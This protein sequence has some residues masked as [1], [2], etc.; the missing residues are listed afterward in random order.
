MIP[1]AVN[2]VNP[3]AQVLRS[4]LFPLA[5]GSISFDPTFYIELTIHPGSDD[6][7][8]ESNQPLEAYI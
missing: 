3:P 4:L 2:D 5:Q 1:P 6:N 7:I 8:F